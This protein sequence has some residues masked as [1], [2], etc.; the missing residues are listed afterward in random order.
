MF[1]I[2]EVFRVVAAVV[3]MS[4]FFFE[5]TAARAENA[6][7][8]PLRVGMERDYPPFCM[9]DEQG[10]VSGFD[11][12]IATALCRNMKREC[13]ILPMAFQDIL[14]AME[15]GRLDIAV[16]GLAVKPDRLRYMNFSDSYYH[17]RS[18]YITGREVSVT[19]EWMRGKKLGTQSG[20]AQRS[21][22][23]KMWKDVAVLCEYPDHLSMIDALKAGEVDVVIIDGLAAYDFLLSR[24]GSTYS[25]QALPLE[26]DSPTNNACIG[27][28]KDDAQLLRDVNTFLNDIRLSS[29]YSRIARKYFPFSIY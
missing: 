10:N 8:P 23:E 15:Q 16:A 5:G 12:D 21:L 9:V 14:D 19:K 29:E 2:A 24:E 7:R 18:I 17:S 26:L 28:R 1:R 25:M 20:T 22:A 13:V 3:L 6:D 11:F 27:V 4:F